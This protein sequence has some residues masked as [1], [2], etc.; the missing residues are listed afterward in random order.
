MF[1]RGL[2]SRSVLWYVLV[3]LFVVARV[4]SY[5]IIQFIGVTILWS[6]NNACYAVETSL[7]QRQAWHH[8]D[9]H[10]FSPGG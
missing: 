2:C 7:V 6:N 8:F 4:A 10:L 1:F 9:H 5:Y 3:E